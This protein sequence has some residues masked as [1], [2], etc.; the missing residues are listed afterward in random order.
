MT[1]RSRNE[2]LVFDHPFRLKGVERL[3]P[4]GSYEVLTDEETIEGL[5]FPC[6]RRIALHNDR[7]GSRD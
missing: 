7:T 6:Y 5:A 2:T 3:F 4:A 1:I